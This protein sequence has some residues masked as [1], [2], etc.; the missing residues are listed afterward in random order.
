MNY[1]V[2]HI[3]VVR[4]NFMSLLKI[5]YSKNIEQVIPTDLNNDLMIFFYFAFNIP[6]L[7]NP[8]ASLGFN[9]FY[10]CI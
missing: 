1:L 10:S 9:Q 6:L 2:L 4:L 7:N 8:L 5:A 3:I